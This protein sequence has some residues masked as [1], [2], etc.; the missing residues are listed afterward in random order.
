VKKIAFNLSITLWCF[1]SW[2]FIT[3]QFE[4]AAKKFI[5]SYLRS[6]KPN[7]K[8]FRVHLLFVATSS[9]FAKWL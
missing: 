7:Q 8:C 5:A 4:Q 3:Q 1:Y 9:F 6:S 2:W